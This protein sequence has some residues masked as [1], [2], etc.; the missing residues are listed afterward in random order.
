VEPPEPVRVLPPRQKGGRPRLARAALGQPEWGPAD[1]GS[2]EADHSPIQNPKPKI[3]NGV[4][5]RG[6][7][8]VKF[9]G[10]W[11]LVDPTGLAAGE[12]LRRDYY[13]LETEDGC[14]YLVYWDRVADAWFLQGIFD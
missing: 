12:P 9:G 6:L 4:P 13:Q 14:A 2:A 11:K 10:P 7:R 3:L 1:V 8:I 5:R